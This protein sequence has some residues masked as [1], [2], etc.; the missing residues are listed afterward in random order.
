VDQEQIPGTPE[1]ADEKATNPFFSAKPA[2]CK[3]SLGLPYTGR[4]IHLKRGTLEIA[5][6]PEHATMVPITL[7]YE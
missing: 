7:P 6:Q 1:R 5:G 3:R 4:L 2:D